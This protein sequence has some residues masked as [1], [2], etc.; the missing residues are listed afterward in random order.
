MSIQRQ[1]IIEITKEPGAI[2]GKINKLGPFE[3][4][5]DRRVVY[6]E[7]R[8]QGREVYAIDIHRSGEMYERPYFRDNER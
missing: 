1:I 5:E 6:W 3:R 4:D 2:V 8:E 7:L